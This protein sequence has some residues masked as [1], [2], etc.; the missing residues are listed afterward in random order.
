MTY[1]AASAPRDGNPMAARN[2]SGEVHMIRW[3]T[4]PDIEPGA[5]D[6]WVTYAT[7]EVFEFVDWIPSPL[8]TDEIL[9]IYE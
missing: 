1:L 5:Q 7:D 4:G 6:Y 8:T 9:A 2:D 3:R